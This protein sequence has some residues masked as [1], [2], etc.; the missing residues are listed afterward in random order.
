MHSHGILTFP[1]KDRYEGM[2]EDGEMHGAGVYVWSTGMIYRGDW[3]RGVMHGCGSRI[4]RRPDGSM[5]AREGKFFG[6]EFVGD[7]MPCGSDDAL[8]SAVEADM[9]AFQARSFQWPSQ[10]QSRSQS[11]HAKAAGSRQQPLHSATAAKQQQQ[12]GSSSSSRAGLQLQWPAAGGPG[13]AA[14]SREQE[15]GQDQRL[16]SLVQR[17]VA[18]R[19]AA[20]KTAAEQRS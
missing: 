1:N 16:Q 2:F 15:Q 9:A 17:L 7:V 6:D 11:W 5:A 8:D 18:D 20:D 3:A 13:G 10:Q 4:W 19:V 14:G 12:L